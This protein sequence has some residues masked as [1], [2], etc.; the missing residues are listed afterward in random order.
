MSGDRA[1]VLVVATVGSGLVAGA[2]TVFGLMV[3]PALTALPGAAG[4][5]AMQSVNRAAVRPGFMTLLF[6]TALVC[7]V[8]GGVE[9]AG[10][11]RPAVL[12]GAALHLFGV[13]GVTVLAN[14]P[15]NDALARL[16]AAAP[17]AAETWRENAAR[18]GRWNT[19]RALAATGAATAFVLVPTD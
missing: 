8:L 18:W 5:T 4:A 3:L 7:L 2:F 19:V 11:R 9:L 1:P 14:V 13:V 12:T 6:G 15:L 17:G 16:D 10:Q